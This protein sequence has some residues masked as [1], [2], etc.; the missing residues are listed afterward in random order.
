[1]NRSIT[2]RLL[3]LTLTFALGGVPELLAQS[4]DPSA[5]PL[6]DAPSATRLIAQNTTAQSP[7]V[8]PA[9]ADPQAQSPQQ[10]APAQEPAPTQ[11]SPRVVPV[12]PQKATGT[13]DEQQQTQ[14]PPAAETTDTSQQDTTKPVIAPADPAEVQKLENAQKQNEPAAPVN[15]RVNPLGTA[16]A[17]KGQTAG[18]GAS[19]P[20]G[21]AIAPAKQKRSRSLLIKLGALAAAGAA[22]GTVY[23][24]S[25]GTGSTPAGAA[26]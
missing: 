19:R 5:K 12:D 21:V 16:A 9:T 26:H 24:L 18:G 14:Q 2:T 13:E 17:E 10:S 11:T 3:I 23:A 8:Q 6:P 22:V 15:E 7:G 25:K 20:A 1:M 4:A